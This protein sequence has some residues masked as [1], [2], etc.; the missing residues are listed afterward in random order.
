[1]SPDR[2]RQNTLDLRKPAFAD[3]VWDWR[4]WSFVNS[5]R[6]KPTSFERKR[7]GPM[8]LFACLELQLR[9]YGPRGMIA[10][11]FVSHLSPYIFLYVRKTVFAKK[12]QTTKKIF[13]SMAGSAFRLHGKTSQI[14]VLPM[15]G[16]QF[17]LKNK[18]NMLGRLGW[19]HCHLADTCKSS[20]Q[21]GGNRC[22]RI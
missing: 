6:R 2:R 11:A 22:I 14:Q 21:D 3:P 4:W 5:R 8:K 9:F 7:K 13:S 18:D 20:R 1:M 19:V 16:S 12:W 17:S 15:C 10:L